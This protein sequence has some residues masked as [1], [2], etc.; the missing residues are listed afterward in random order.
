MLI[1]FPEGM[2]PK[3]DEWYSVTGELESIYYQPFKKTIPLLKVSSHSKIAKPDDP[4]VYR[5][6]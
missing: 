4:Y 2:H 6:Y 5:Q 1:E 3:N